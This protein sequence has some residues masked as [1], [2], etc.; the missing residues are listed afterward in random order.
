MRLG[1]TGN[2]FTHITE[3]QGLAS[4]FVYG[5]LADSQGALWFSTNR[6]IVR[7][8]P[9]TLQ[10][11]HF[12][13]ADG[14]GL[15]EFNSGAFY[16]RGDTLYFG[17]AGGMVRFNSM[18]IAQNNNK[19][20]VLMQNL[21][22]NGKKIDVKH[23]TDKALTLPEGSYL[24]LE[25]AASDY[26]NPE[27]NSFEFQLKPEHN[28]MQALGHERMVSLSQLPNGPVELWA[29]AANNQG[30]WGA[31]R[32]LLQL[33]VRPV[34]YKRPWFI[35][36]LAGV[37]AALIWLWYRFRLAQQRALALAVQQEND[38]VRQLA[39]QDIHDE[40]GNS[41]TRIS[42]LAELV[43]SRSEA[44]NV[45]LQHLAGKIYD[46]AQRLYQGTKDF[47]WSINLENNSVQELATRLKDYV[48]E[49]LDHSHIQFV[50]LGL[51]DTLADWQLN[52]GQNRQVLMI[53]KEAISNSI[54]HAQKADRMELSFSLEGDILQIVWQ[55]NGQNSNLSQTN[56]FG[57]HNMRQ[58]AE[59]I[60]ATLA[61][62]AEAS[63]VKVAL[64]VG[65]LP[66]NNNF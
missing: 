10:M 38:R 40:F 19:P 18:A 41:L 37:V 4:G 23:L 60:Q 24:Q 12:S 32:Q 47:V 1:K 36:A 52:P 57:L 5:G 26:T 34:L 66:K 6:G 8:L 59:K 58:R 31:E 28:Q 29:K 50:C 20:T 33:Y 56:G 7:I 42:L 3:A 61:I 2:Q 55:D 64:C 49:V 27:Q 13:S 17:G 14:L 48:D 15:T 16:Q 43:R 54:K 63:G 46:N 25:L 62:Q 39:A 53:F 45:E 30:L 21:W 51:D 22:V 65:I 11:R 35:M 44:H 9:S